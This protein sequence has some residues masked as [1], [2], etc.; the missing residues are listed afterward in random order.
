MKKLSLVLTSILACF[1]LN[2][3]TIALKGVNVIDVKNGQVIENQTIVINGDKIE[4]VKASH[5]VKIPQGTAVV[6]LTGK[7]VSPGLIDAHVHHATDP[8]TWDNRSDTLQRLRTLLRGGVTSV[9]DM[10]GD[11]RVLSGLK[12]AAQLDLI[13][14]PDIYYSIIIGGP[15][16]FEDPRTVSS[17]KGHKSGEVPWMA[18][19]TDD[20][21]LDAVMLKAIG[22]GATG[23]KIYAAINQAQIAKLA[24]AAKKHGLKVW[25]HVFVGPAKPSEAIN[26]GVETISHA[27]DFSA[28]VISNY[29]K[30]RR[31]NEA[32]DAEEEKQSYQAHR[33]D[34]VFKAM[35][36][37]NTILDATMIVFEQRK[38]M[39]INTQKRYKHTQMLTKL[40]HA[41]GVDIAA[42]TDAAS[43]NDV[44]LYKELKLLVEEAGMSP[45]QAL[46]SATYINSKV[47]GQEAHLGT[48]ETGKIAN[49]VIYEK[50][51]TAD[52]IHLNSISHV[53]KNGQFIY[54][55]VDKRLPFVPAKKV[56]NALWMS[57][58]IGNLPG[59]MTLVSNNIEDQMKQTM[60]N[61]GQVLQE[62]GLSYKNITK[63]T[64]MLADIKDWPKANEVYKGFF[65][66]SLPTRSAFGANG[67]A[68]GAKVEVECLANY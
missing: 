64:L 22:A 23:I 15:D 50:N 66:E 12:R 4:T 61:I 56:G 13:Q 5:N 32:P 26:A 21:N 35:K 55:G 51:P 65:T 53:I 38:E 41:R 9:R 46:K 11:T 43:D 49:L 60:T 27:P 25:S 45:I 24:K 59:T 54:R 52:I 68:L 40:A 62:Y 17:A 3:Q 31:E 14:S 28:E 33:Y 47:I 44:Q 10:G 30:W 19:I 58:Q 29:R 57:G 2:A 36:S 8:E 7:F 48:I 37:K 16:F 67:L 18:A 34:A 1:S 42:G 63:C 20:T 39:N 6:D